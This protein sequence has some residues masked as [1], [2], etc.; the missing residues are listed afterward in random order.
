M[1]SI[2][3]LTTD[4]LLK[5]LGVCLATYLY[6]NIIMPS[7]QLGCRL[8]GGGGGM[9]RTIRAHNYSDPPIYLRFSELT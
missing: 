5:L 2:N 4:E 3:Q 6:R 9:I 7:Q 1:H 8:G